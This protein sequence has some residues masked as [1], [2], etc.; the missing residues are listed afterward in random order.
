MINSMVAVVAKEREAADGVPAAPTLPAPPVALLPC[1]TGGRIAT[2]RR[3]RSR[4]PASA[5]LTFAPRYPRVATLGRI[6]P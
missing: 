4:N 5:G 1:G 2:T 6:V 3:E